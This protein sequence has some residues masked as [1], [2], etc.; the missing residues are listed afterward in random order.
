MSRT[1]QGVPPFIY[2]N[3][4]C[5]CT[6]AS[7]FASPEMRTAFSLLLLFSI[8]LAHAVVYIIYYII[9]RSAVGIVLAILYYIITKTHTA[10]DAL[11]QKR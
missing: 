9:M 10:D 1:L 4:V 8:R 2:Y 3:I 7:A 11:P 5:V 6:S